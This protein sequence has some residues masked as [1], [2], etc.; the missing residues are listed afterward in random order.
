MRYTGC[1]GEDHGPSPARARR[2]LHGGHKSYGAQVYVGFE[3]RGVL[4]RPEAGRLQPPRSF[5]NDHSA[6]SPTETLLRLLLPL[7]D[8]V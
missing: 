8:Q 2:L 7:N 1:N 4:A 3:V 6:G 5:S